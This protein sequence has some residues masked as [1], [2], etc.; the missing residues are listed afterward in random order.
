MLKN[1]FY[2]T[3]GLRLINNRIVSFPVHLE[4][5]LLGIFRIPKVKSISFL[6]NIRPLFLKR[7]REPLQM[8]IIFENMDLVN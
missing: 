4:R 1:A 2:V 7:A 6:E 3:I 5:E 8:F